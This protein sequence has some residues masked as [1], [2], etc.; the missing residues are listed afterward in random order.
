MKHLRGFHILRN[1]IHLSS[2]R[3]LS[4]CFAFLYFESY[5]H[6]TIHMRRDVKKI[7][8]YEF[9]FCMTF[10]LI[11]WKNTFLLLQIPNYRVKFWF[12]FINYSYNSLILNIYLRWLIYSFHS[13]KCL[14]YWLTFKA[15]F[16]GLMFER[17][18]NIT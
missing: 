13:L 7:F 18:F 15:L 3:L 5:F 12:F 8:W 17:T 14:S 10:Y 11:L 6:L 4:L 16:D 9:L 1:R 2:T